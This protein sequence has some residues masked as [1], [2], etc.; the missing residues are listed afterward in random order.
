MDSTRPRIR[1]WKR[2][3][4]GF[5]VCFVFA[6]AYVISGLYW[7]VHSVI[8]ES[9]AAWT[10]GDLVVEYMQTHS[11]QWP[12]S[13]E[14]LNAA[15]ETLLAKGKPLHTVAEQLPRFVRIDWHADITNLLETARRDSN[16][17]VLVVTKADGS[18]LR[19]VWGPDTEPNAKIVRYLETTVTKTTIEPKNSSP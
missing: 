11:N 12:R 9:Y 7:V 6:A 17:P 2:V 1:V 16:V 18:R 10:T 19:A 8:P 13:W 5:G 3:L 14:D 4:I 15:R